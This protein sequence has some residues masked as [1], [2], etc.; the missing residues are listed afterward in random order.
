VE[1]DIIMIVYIWLI[2]SD[3]KAYM[4]LQVYF[5]NIKPILMS[6]SGYIAIRVIRGNLSGLT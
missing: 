6:M 2:S 3:V 5:G 1:R 4:H